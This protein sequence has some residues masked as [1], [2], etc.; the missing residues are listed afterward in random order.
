[1]TFSPQY[2][3]PGLYE[4]ENARIEQ[5]RVRAA[6]QRQQTCDM[7]RQ[8]QNAFTTATGATLALQQ[9]QSAQYAQM[10]RRPK[11]SWVQSLMGMPF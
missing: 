4:D 5:E 2:I 3:Y 1:M 10:M 9:M 7:A 11:P 8:M 6:Q